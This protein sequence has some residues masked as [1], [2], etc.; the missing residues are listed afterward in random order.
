M[1]DR[2]LCLRRE[3]RGGT[4]RGHDGPVAGGEADWVS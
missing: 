3:A 2:G 4:P 1:H